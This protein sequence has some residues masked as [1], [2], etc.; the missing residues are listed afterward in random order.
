[1]TVVAE[2]PAGGWPV[3][4][5]GIHH[6]AVRV[7]DFAAAV[8]FYTEALGFTE[9]VTWGDPSR[10]SAMLEIGQG[11]Y[12]EVFSGGNDD[13]KPDGALLHLS[14]RTPDCDA[15][16]ARVRAAGGEI[17]GEP[18]DAVTQGHQRTIRARL[19]FCRGPAGERIEFFQSDEM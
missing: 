12:L 14:L 9:D 5:Y 4:P 16:I 6:V 19:A 18:R 13:P 1:M 8:R 10:P 3:H 17:L 7:P 11:T 15:A 2:R